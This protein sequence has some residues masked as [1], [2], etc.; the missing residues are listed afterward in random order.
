MAWPSEWTGWPN[1]RLPSDTK[2]AVRQLTEIFSVAGT[3]RL[4]IA[5]HGRRGR[6]G[7]AFAILAIKSGVGS[8]AAVEWVRQHY[9]DKAVETP[10]QRRWVEKHK[11]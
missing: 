2:S 11:P 4:E 3:A 7:T 5:R 1:F 8:A 10:W 6:T 9:D